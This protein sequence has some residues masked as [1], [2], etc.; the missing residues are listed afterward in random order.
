MTASPA[1]NGAEGKGLDF[2]ALWEGAITWTAY[3][4]PEMEH[5]ELWRGVY[6]HAV[7]P[8]WALEGFARAP[9]RRL[10]VLA[11]DWC[12]DAANSVPVLA[13]LV[14]L[15]RGVELRV[16]ER[17]QFPEV[18]NRYLTNGTRS[19]PIALLLDE[20]FGE[21]GHWGPRPLPLQTW[22]TA[23]KK[24]IPSPQ[25]YAYARKWYAKDRGETMLREMLE[26]TGRG[27]R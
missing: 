17:D 18:M 1:P 14:E 22:V 20:G 3:L 25:R 9:V 8:G 15:L 24:T 5:A 16:L 11:A 2:A 7:V 13:R 21:L 10:L 19:I 4:R 12:G 23:N 26:Q 27:E 6:D